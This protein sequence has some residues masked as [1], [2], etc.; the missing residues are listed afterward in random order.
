MFIFYVLFFFSP[1]QGSSPPAALLVLTAAL[2]KPFRQLEKYPGVAQEVEQHL[3][4]D[5]A[6]RGD[7]QRSIGFYKSVAVRF[8]FCFCFCFCFFGFHFLVY[9]SM[10]Q[11]VKRLL[12]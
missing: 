7:T 6:D 12:P 1:D 11:R 3:E 10:T 5:H 9:G 8:F 2:S 4:D